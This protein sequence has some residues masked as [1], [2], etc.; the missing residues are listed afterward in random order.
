MKKSFIILLMAVI[1]FVATS[2]SSTM[3][4][5]KEPTVYFELNSNDYILSDQVTGEA[6]V[7]RVFGIDFARLFVSKAGQFKTPVVGLP[8]I[9]TD[10]M[11]AI[12]DM[13]EKNP[14]YDFVFYPQ[15]YTVSEGLPGIYVNTTVK[16]TARLGKL[17]KKQ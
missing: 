1:G 16:V 4:T 14:G 9:T 5:M 15:V 8:N 7:Q 17:K 2:C 11:Y 3:Q 13:M 10:S 12:Y 6:T